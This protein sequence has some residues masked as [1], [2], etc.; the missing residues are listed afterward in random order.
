MTLAE[1]ILMATQLT[2]THLRAKLFK[3]LDQVIV[4]GESVEIQRP[5]GCVRLVAAE[6]SGRLARLRPHPGTIIGNPDDL[7]DLSWED[8][9]RPNLHGPP[10]PSGLPTSGPQRV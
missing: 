4:T 10:G 1:E 8:V 5:G 6:S 9:W 2:A 7:A 3:T